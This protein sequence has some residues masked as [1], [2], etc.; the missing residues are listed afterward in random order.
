M[1][2]K[3]LRTDN[4]LEFYNREFM[5]LCIESRI[6][7]HLTVARTPQ[8]NGLAEL[9]W[10]RKI[11]H[12]EDQTNPEDGDDEDARDQEIDYPSD[13]TDYQLVQDREPRKRTKPLRF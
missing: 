12:N 1:T 13:L 11:K 9:S 4:C 7:R 2:V 6:A 8:Q 5:Q 10:I 3:K